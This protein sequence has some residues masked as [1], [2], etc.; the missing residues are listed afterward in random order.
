MDTLIEIEIRNKIVY[1]N[2][3]VKSFEIYL[4]LILHL[5]WKLLLLNNYFQCI[6]ND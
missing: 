4:L 2:L 6:A 3:K 5:K 1:K